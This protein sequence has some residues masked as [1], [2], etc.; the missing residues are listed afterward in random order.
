[1]HEGLPSDDVSN[2]DVLPAKATSESMTPAHAI[3]EHPL[4]V[5]EIALTWRCMWGT[6]RNRG[7]NATLASAIGAG[8]WAQERREAGR[9][10]TPCSLARASAG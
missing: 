6:R 1:M 5:R 2:F 3:H 10:K 4:Q 7:S 8:V 9:E